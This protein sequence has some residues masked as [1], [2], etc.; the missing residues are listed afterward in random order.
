MKYFSVTDI[1]K[2][3]EKN[4]DSYFSVKKQFDYI[5]LGLFMIADGMGGHEKGEFASSQS[6]CIVNN[7]INNHLENIDFQNID[8]EMING[9]LYDSIKKA[10]KFIFESAPKNTIMGTTFVLA[11]ILNEKLFIANVGDS[12]V[13]MLN[14]NNL[15]Q[16]TK[17]NSYVQQLIEGGYIDQEEAKTHSQRN[18]ITRAIGVEK[19]IQVDF[20]IRELQKEDKILLCSDGLTTMVDDEDIK[21]I[22]TENENP[23]DVC[24]KLLKMAND[25]GGRDNITITNV[26]I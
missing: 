6:V 15:V 24:E 5:E 20:Y 8:D 19:D 18:Q 3:R 1:G 12:R 2:K 10:N 23:K 17:D 7:N 11:L 14:S 13:Y 25:N 22:L 21:I 26:I 9:I 16:I 4:E